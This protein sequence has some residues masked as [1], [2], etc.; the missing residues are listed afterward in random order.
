MNKTI[1]LDKD[2]EEVINDFYKEKRRHKKELPAC[3]YKQKC[4][5]YVY[6]HEYKKYI[7]KKGVCG[8]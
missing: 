7:C 1:T 5:E 8:L 2:K 4:K 3:P 6:S